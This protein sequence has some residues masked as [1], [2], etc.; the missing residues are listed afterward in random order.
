M[1]VASYWG[2]A[3]NF[4]FREISDLV[5]RSNSGSAAFAF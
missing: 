4:G 5:K 1:S 3:V 2:R